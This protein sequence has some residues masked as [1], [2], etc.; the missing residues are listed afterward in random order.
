MQFKI[1]YWNSLVFDSRVEQKGKELTLSHYSTFTSGY[2][3]V[4]FLFFLG[5]ICFFPKNIS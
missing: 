4:I 3:C 1:L 5:G 2:L